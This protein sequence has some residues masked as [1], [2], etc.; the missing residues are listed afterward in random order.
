MQNFCQ[1]S[2]WGVNVCMLC[3]TVCDS[4][5]DES[6]YIYYYVLVIK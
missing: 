1:M 4:D 2:I 3:V 6:V 5:I